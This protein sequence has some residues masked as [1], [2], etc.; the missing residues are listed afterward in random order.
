IGCD[1]PGEGVLQR[2][3]DLGVPS[4]LFS[5]TELRDG[6]VQQELV[7]QGIGLVVLAGFLRLVPSALVGAFPDRIVNIHPALLPAH[8]GKG[9]Y[10]RHVH[11][12]VLAAGE[13]ESG[14][15]VHLVNEHYDE[16]E[17]LFQARCPVL[18]DDTPDSLAVRIHELEHRHYPQVVEKLA[19]ALAGR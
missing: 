6:T 2:A 18:P 12:A 4:L 9:M 19:E 11:E 8:G 16:G 7:G 10:G 15:T 3:W 17:H 1:R 14:I 5:G 13:P